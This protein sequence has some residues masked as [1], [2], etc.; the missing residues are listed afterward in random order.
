MAPHQYQLPTR[1]VLIVGEEDNGRVTINASD[2]DPEK[3]TPCDVDGNPLE[4][5]GDDENADTNGDGTIDEAEAKAA[6]EKKAAKEKAKAER[7]A[8]KKEQIPLRQ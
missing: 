2:F 4:E 6:A 3:H 7:K 5:G 8:K 1:H